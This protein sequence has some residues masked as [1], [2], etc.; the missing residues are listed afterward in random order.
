MS[1]YQHLS[2]LSVLSALSAVSFAAPKPQNWNTIDWNNVGVDWSTVNYGGGQPATVAT[3][4]AQAQVTTVAAVVATTAPHTSTSVVPHST[5]SPTPSSSPKSDSSSGSSSSPSGG[6][7]GLAYNPSSPS[8]D[9]FSSY[10]AIGWGWD[11]DSARASLPSQYEFVPMLWDP[12]HAD[13][14]DSDMK[15]SSASYLLSFNEPDIPSQANMPVA[16]AV[17]GHVQ[18]MNKHASGS[19]KIG[20]VSVSNGASQ[21][22]NAPMGLDYLKAFLDQCGSSSPACVVDFCP[23]H[24]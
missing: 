14:F 17:A 20:A 6:K 12:S 24:W 4:R 7:R 13:K 22:P 21:D 1:R 18:H 10:S 23:V 16:S 15:S 8:L 5:S 11:W 19:V 2:V 3:T 9:I